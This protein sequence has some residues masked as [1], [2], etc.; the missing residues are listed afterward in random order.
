[1][2]GKVEQVTCR[3]EVG[4]QQCSV[5]T[6]ILILVVVGVRTRQADYRLRLV[7]LAQILVV[8]RVEKL[9]V[10]ISHVNPVQVER[11]KLIA[12]ASVAALPRVA[13][14]HTR[15]VATIIWAILIVER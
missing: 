4:T 10:H 12:V 8:Q 5:A 7:T 11:A 1:V 2:L 13:P 9:L 14:R 6:H 3:L 15:K